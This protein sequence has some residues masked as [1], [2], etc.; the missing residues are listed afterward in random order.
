MFECG[1]ATVELK[2]KAMSDTVDFVVVGAG[3]A[4]CVLANRLSENGRY[5]VCLLEAGPPDKNIW[6]HIPIGYGKTMFNKDLNWGFH[7][8]PDPN[9]L[10]R[11]IYWP[12]GK[13]LGGCSSIN[14]LIYVRGQKEDY[15]AWEEQGNKGWNWE[16]C[17]PYFRKLESND[18]GEGPTRGTTGPLHATSIKTRHELVEALIGAAGNNGIKRVKDFNSGDQEG[19]GYY[20]LTTHNGMRCSAAVAYLNPARGRPNLRIITN[21]QAT[22]IVLEGK[23]ATGVTYRKGDRLM[24]IKANKEVIL[25]AGALQSPQLL[26]LSGVGPSLLLKKFGIPVVKELAGVGENLQDHLQLRL[27]YEVAKPITTNDQLRSL[28]GRA[29]MGLQW[30]LFRGGPLAIGINQGAIFCKAL[31]GEARTPDIQFH[32]GTLSAD[33]A[34]GKVHD[35]SGCTYSVCQLRPESRGYVRIKSANPFEAPSMQPNYL[36][37]DLDRRTAI[38]G[39]KF[40]RRIAATEPMKSLMKREH[41]PGQDVNTDDEILHFC[42]EYG[43]TIFHPCGTARMGQASDP[44]AVVDERLRVY[45]V[46]GLR[47]VDA[48]IMPTL[49]SGNTN[50]PIVMVAERASDFILEDARCA[51]S[52][53]H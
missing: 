26:Q 40:A 39:V 36:S 17:L 25:S 22:G 4:G 19:A 42:R 44:L 33:M 48:S 20:Q 6:I 14:G 45:G 11:E 32:F 41:R 18:L 10:N 49:V 16:E 12:R 2:V 29:K 15:D 8:D 31:P 23:R 43:A 9:M 38:A 35:F 34:G 21:A 30:A 50:V 7:T 13:T 27:I 46:A 37:T 52:V 3:S 53:L 51:P 28:W 5:S 1:Q 24:T 47:V